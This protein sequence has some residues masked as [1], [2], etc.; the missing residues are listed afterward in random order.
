MGTRL[1][2]CALTGALL[3]AIGQ[4]ASAAAPAKEGT[5]EGLTCYTGPVQVIAG[6]KG[7]TAGSYD[8][9]GTPIR[10]DGELG[11]QSSTR[12][13]GTFLWAGEESSDN[14]SCVAIDPDGDLVFYVYARKN[15]EPGTWKSLGGTGKYEGIDASGTNAP[16][17]RPIRGMRPDIL[18]TC[19]R[20]TG[21]WTLR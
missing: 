15:Q 11:Y 16:A 5:F 3:I 14:G 21:R 7:R 9:V 13:V 8:I 12:C 6:V 20:E 19:L 4:A 2:R 1:E 10:K 17:V 18:Q